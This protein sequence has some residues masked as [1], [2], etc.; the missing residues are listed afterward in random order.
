MYIE[1][2]ASFE[3]RYTTL[4]LFFGTDAIQVRTFPATLFTNGRNS[5]FDSLTI[6]RGNPRY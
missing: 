4:P 2:A 5:A 3:L 1:D 6:D